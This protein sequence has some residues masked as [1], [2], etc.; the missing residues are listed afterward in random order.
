M[1][2]GGRVEDRSAANGGRVQEGALVG[3][4]YVDEGS[5]VDGGQV[6]DEFVAAL[7]SL[8][9]TLEDRRVVEQALDRADR[10][11]QQR[12]QG[13]GYRELVAGSERPLIVELV[14][15]RLEEI[16]SAG[17]RFR[18]AAAAGLYEEGMT[19]EEIAATFGVSRQRVSTIL[20]EGSEQAGEGDHD[21][22]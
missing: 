4:G 7:E 17:A 3:A 16:A 8:T 9:R 6:E 18:R 19:M 1:A 21:Q 10:L 13:A 12:E 11:R 5:L 22:R 15:E 2:N 20:R 14:S